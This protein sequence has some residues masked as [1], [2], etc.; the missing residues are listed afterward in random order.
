MQLHGEVNFYNAAAGEQLTLPGDQIDK[1]KSAEEAAL[2]E[3]REEVNLELP[4]AAELGILD[5][6]RTRSGYLITPMGVLADCDMEGPPMKLLPFTLRHF[7]T[8]RRAI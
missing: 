3:V 1:G 8:P 7:L 5:D 6:H 2:R 4:A